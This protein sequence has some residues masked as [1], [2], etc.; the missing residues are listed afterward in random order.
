MTRIKRRKKRD[1][2]RC[3]DMGRRT[4]KTKKESRRIDGS[5]QEEKR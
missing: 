3:E 2:K 1:T 4:V 5:R